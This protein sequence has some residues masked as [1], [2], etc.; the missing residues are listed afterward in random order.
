MGEL[1]KVLDFGIAKLL[2]A[3]G[4]R[5]DP[6]LTQV[7][8]RI[9]TPEYASP[10]QVRGE[11]VTVATDVYSLGVVL[12]WL[13][14]GQSPYGPTH[15]TPH[16]VEQAVVDH[17]PARPST[18]VSTP[19]TQRTAR[20]AFGVSAQRLSRRLDGDLDNIALK[21][22]QKDPTRRY[23]SAA[24]LADDVRRYLRNE[25]VQARGDAWTYVAGK[26]VTRHARSLLVA[27]LVLAGVAAQTAFYTFKLKDERDRAN[28]AATQSQEVAG[29]LEHLFESASPHTAKG[30]TPT[31]V[32]LLE[33][34]VADIDGLADQ[35][36]V[37]AELKRIMG[38]SFLGLGE[39]N[40]AR[41]LLVDALA[42]KTADAT[43]PLDL[44]EAHHNLSEAHRHFG[45]LDDAERELRVALAI[46][47]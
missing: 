4:L 29:F 31:A 9:L 45:D 35:P 47:E 34:G 23:P 24:A 13:M 1:T 41:E 18:V 17:T 20:A 26:F 7:G 5:G 43:S 16:D 30:N 11:P 46:R 6:G 42:A 12:Y 3:D 36:R 8:A 14:T 32:D 15:K 2:G 22:L 28:V 40:R 10:E 19:D 44:A 21:T 39:V 27:G 25:P 38:N 33:L 37:Q